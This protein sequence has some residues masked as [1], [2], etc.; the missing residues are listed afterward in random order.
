MESPTW[1]KD[2]SE[3]VPRH[4][5][6]NFPRR[7]VAE[8]WAAHELEAG[9]GDGVDL[10]DV[11]AGASRREGRVPADPRVGVGEVL[12]AQEVV[13]GR[14]PARPSRA[15]RAAV[16]RRSVRPCS[17]DARAGCRRGPAPARRAAPLASQ[18]CRISHRPSNC[19][20]ALWCSTACAWRNPR[21]PRRPPRGNSSEVDG[22]RGDD[23]ERA[24]RGILADERAH[25]VGVAQALLHEHAAALLAGASFARGAS[26][27]ITG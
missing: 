21:R 4:L 16:G 14:A 13:Q 3:G 19:R 22:L 5:G 9:A 23:A 11:E 20:R 25:A 8:V 15:P 7:R 10:E 1:A 18:R 27:L 6:E 12:G 2:G 17:G 24:Q 26:G